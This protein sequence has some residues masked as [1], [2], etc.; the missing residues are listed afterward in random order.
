MS[1]KTIYRKDI[2]VLRGVAVFAVVLFHAQESYIPLGFL[3]VDAFF[4]ISGFVVTP[5]IIQ[6]FTEQEIYGGRLSKLKYFYKRRF[7]RLAPALGTILFTSAIFTFLL[8][9]INILEQFSG[10]GAAA[11]LLSG[12]LAAYRY[13]P[14]YLN[15]KPNLLNH[16]WSLSVEEQIYVFLP[17]IFL[18]FFSIF[19]ITHKKIFLLLFLITTISL[20]ISFSPAIL[21][22]IYTKIGIDSPS[23]FSFYS[24]VERIYQFTLGSLGYLISDNYS[25]KIKKIFK[26]FNWAFISIILLFLFVPITIE[27]KLGSIFASLIT[28][29]AIIFRSFS[30]LPN[31]ISKKIEW[32]G[33]RSYSIYLIHLPLIYIAKLSP[34]VSINKS[35][36]RSFQVVLAVIATIVLGSISYSKI[37]NKFRYP[38]QKQLSTVKLI[39]VFNIL[40]LMVFILIYSGTQD[41]FWG[42][43]K[44]PIRPLAAWHI[45][46]NCD[47]FGLNG[48]PCT[49]THPSSTKTVLLLGDSHATHLSQAVIEAAK[50]QN[51]NSV[52]WGGT[53]CIFELDICQDKYTSIN[54]WI[55]LNKPTT[56]IV[57]F[58]IQPDVSQPNVL[59]TL[60]KLKLISQNVLLVENN[61]IFPDSNT[62]MQSSNPITI[63]PYDQPKYF[64]KSMMQ[65]KYRNSSDKLAL[66]AK[67]NGIFTLNLESLFCKNNVCFRYLDGEWLYRDADHF[68]IKG[69]EL[70]IPEFN[71]FFASLNYF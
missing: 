27:P 31:S 63:P 29:F 36:N 24:P 1:S 51:W 23:L 37:E 26:Y 11:L 62:F 30:V 42:L 28:L 14:N 10:Q 19:K 64:A 48:L 4:V 58:S 47:R 3:G 17:L 2:Q 46:Q 50:S 5:L 16:T 40:P 70:V 66:S 38:S 71:R 53:G 15:A 34:V 41:K 8:A 45:D 35:E 65:E 6:I 59:N 12:N 55:H 56:V 49:Y 39:T 18:L 21:Q 61:P 52:I 44:N 43:D 9:P 67:N 32:V 54:K 33:D 13:D 25:I 68:S 57:S 22:Q 7:Y 69:A 60:S 20:I